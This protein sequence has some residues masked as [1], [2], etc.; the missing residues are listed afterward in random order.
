MDKK[1]VLKTGSSSEIGKV[2]CFLA[3]EDADFINDEVIKIY[4]GY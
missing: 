1:V 2:I 3:S 4:G